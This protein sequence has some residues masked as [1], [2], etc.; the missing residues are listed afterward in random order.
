MAYGNVH[1]KSR[2]S[3]RSPAA[4]GACDYCGTLYNLVDLK[5]QYEWYGT[6]LTNTGFKAC[7]RCLSKPQDQLR[8]I[9]LPPD[10]IPVDQPRPPY[11]AQ[12]IGL[13]GFTQYVLWPGGFP[14]AEPVYLTDGNGHQILNDL[15][16]PILI[17][18]DANPLSVLQQI[19]MDSGIPIPGNIV[20]RSGTIAQGSVAQQIMA[21]NPARTWLAIFDPSAY[22]IGVSKGTATFSPFT[23]IQP[24]GTIETTI[25]VGFGGALFWAT[26]QSLGTVYQGALTVISQSAGQ[27]FW[28]WEA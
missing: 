28:A 20:D 18:D 3:W 8:P 2:V 17:S 9:I 6:N 1:G 12:V 14:L 13:E 22:P 21:A 15:G 23:V 10:P 4:F 24:I 11:Y 26:A 25:T 7:R 27:A 16:Q 19:A 5:F